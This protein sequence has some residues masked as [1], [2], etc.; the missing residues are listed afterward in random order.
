M[1]L[2]LAEGEQRLYGGD[3]AAREQCSY[4][5]A[6]E[7]GSSVRGAERHS[8]GSSFQIEGMREGAVGNLP[9]FKE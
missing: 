3:C 4:N 5:E 2:R 1:R 6:G 9:I 8:R 7:K